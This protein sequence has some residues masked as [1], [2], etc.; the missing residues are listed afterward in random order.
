M[1]FLTT[2]VLGTEA[3]PHTVFNHPPLDEL[4]NQGRCCHHQYITTIVSI[5][6]IVTINIIDTIVTMVTVTK[7]RSR[8]KVFS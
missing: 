2:D 1:I 8:S 6:T 5:I 4:N 7:S 3:P